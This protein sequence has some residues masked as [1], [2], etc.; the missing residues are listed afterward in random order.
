MQLADKLGAQ[1]H[2]TASVRQSAGGD[3]DDHY[4]G[5]SD[6]YDRYDRYDHY[7]GG[8]DH[9]DRYDHDDDCSTDHYDHVVCTRCARESGSD[10]LERQLGGVGEI[11]LSWTSPYPYDGGSPVTDYIVEY[12]TCSLPC[13][14]SDGGGSWA[15]SGVT[16][17]TFSD[18]TSDTTSATVTGLEHATRYMFRVYAVNAVGTSDPSNAPYPS[19][20][21]APSP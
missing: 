20:V 14:F 5:G 9:Y 2:R 3:N 18:G 19:V 4:D 21:T 13:N 7:D 6:H 8:S 17:T 1:R 16:W 10:R 12:A 11:D 15:D